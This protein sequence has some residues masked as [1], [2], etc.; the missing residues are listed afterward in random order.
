MNREW[1]WNFE[2]DW[3]RFIEWISELWERFDSEIENW[4]WLNEIKRFSI[5]EFLKHWREWIF[6]RELKFE[7]RKNWG[8]WKKFQEKAPHRVKIRKIKSVNSGG[9]KPPLNNKVFSQIF[10]FNTIFRGLNQT[11]AKNHSYLARFL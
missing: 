3:A 10:L 7:I 11:S 1:D 5:S 2:S 6:C 4:E 9:F 8:N